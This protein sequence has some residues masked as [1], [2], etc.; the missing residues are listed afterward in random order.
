MFR[1]TKPNWARSL[2]KPMCGEWGLP[3]I[4]MDPLASYRTIL[5]ELAR[6]SRFCDEPA[7]KTA[8]AR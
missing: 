4:E 6:I 1:S 8:A 2:V 3:Y 5:A 7:G